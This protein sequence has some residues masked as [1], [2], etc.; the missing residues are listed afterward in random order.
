MTHEHHHE[1]CH[2]HG[3]SHDHHH[4]CSCGCCAPRT[5]LDPAAIPAEA[6]S[7]ELTGRELAVLLTIEGVG[8]LPVARLLATRS[9]EDEV[10]IDCLSPVYLYDRTDTLDEVKETGA[11]LRGLE[12]KG[13]LSLDY[14]RPI[15]N[16][17]D[18]LYT[19]S[20]LFAYFQRT[21]QEASGREGFLCDTAEIEVGSMALTE[22]GSVVCRLR[23][24][25]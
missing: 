8:C 7:I 9:D 22:L 2:E 11:L 12:E 19:Q 21:V 24:P 25:S 5:P 6:A 4:G 10:V 18:S 14:D 23:D 15:L 20:D 3:H 16:Y 1:H 17:D 13:L